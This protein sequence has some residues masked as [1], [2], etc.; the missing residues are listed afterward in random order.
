M[1][2]DEEALLPSGKDDLRREG[3]SAGKKTSSGSSGKGV[4]GVSLL[5]LSFSSRGCDGFE[6]LVRV[7]EGRASWGD[8][9]LNCST[10]YIDDVSIW[11]HDGR[12]INWHPTEQ[13]A[14]ASFL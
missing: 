13:T 12:N 4:G 6:L 1:E 7:M 14:E 9:M 3:L 2:E 10:A 5:S 11:F 8:I